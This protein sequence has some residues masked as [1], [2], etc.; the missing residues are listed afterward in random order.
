MS[1][2]PILHREVRVPPSPTSPALILNIDTVGSSQQR[3]LARAGSKRS[4]DEISSG[5]DEETYARKHLATEG[6]VFFRSSQR[7]PRS[8]LWRTLDDRRVLEIQAV[9]IVNDSYSGEGNGWL[10]YRVHFQDAIL[11]GGVVLADPEETDA[12]ECFVFTE[13]K[14]LFTIT[15]KRDLLTRATLPA[16]F[17]SATCVKRYS[18]SFLGLR[19]PYR[20]HAASS[21]ELL[22]SLTDGSLVRL[23]RRAG[24]NGAQWRETIFSEGGWSGSFSLKKMIPFSSQRTVRYGDSELDASAIVD[25]ARTPDSLHIWTLTLDHWLKMW[26]IKTGKVVSKLDL[27][28]EARDEAR[29][30]PFVMSAE[31]GKLMQ[32][33]RIRKSPDSN[34]VMQVDEEQDWASAYY[35]VVQSPKDHQFKFYKVTPNYSSIEGHT[36]N[37]EDQHSRNKLIPPVDELM[38]TNVW[39]LEDFHVR[40]GFE[41]VDTMLWIR[42][43]S[44]TLCRTFALTFDLLMSEDGEAPNTS[45]TWRNAWSA[46]D[47]GPL[48]SEELKLS[49]GYPGELEVRSE[50]ASTPSEKWLAFLFYPDRFSL[51][52]LDAALYIYRK[53]RGL[54]STSSRGVKAA[55]QPLEERLATAITSKIMLKRSANDQPDYVRYQQDIQ[56]QWQTYYSLLSHLHNRRHEPIG[57]AFDNAS[58]LAWS[59][60]ADYVAPIRECSG[61]ELRILNTHLLD[62]NATF[63]VDRKLHGLIYPERLSKS[64]ANSYES[65]QL[66]RLLAAARDLRRSLTGPVQEKIRETAATAALE[67][68]DPSETGVSEPGRASSIFDICN[69]DSEVT[70]EDFEALSLGVESLGGLGSLQDFSILGILEWI[71]TEGNFAGHDSGAQLTPFGPT[72]LTA[73]VEETLRRSESIL[74]ELITLVVFMAGGLEAEELDPEFNADQ[75]YDACVDRLRRVDLLLWLVGHKRERTIRVG[76][77]EVTSEVTLFEDVFVGDWRALQSH[78]RESQTM[79]ELLTVWIKAWISGIKCHGPA[80]EGTT[81]HIL[82]FLVN[83]KESDLALDFLPFMTAETTSWSSY[84]KARMCVDLGDYAQAS[85]YFKSAAEGCAA[86]KNIDSTDTAELLSPDEQ[87]YFGSGLAAYHQHVAALFE[88]LRVYSYVADFARLALR[89]TERIPDF[90]AAMARLDRKKQVHDSPARD[91]ISVAQE[92]QRLLKIKEAR[93]DILNRL[94]NAL[95]QTGRWSEAYEA[96]KEIE[97]QPMKRADLRRLLESCVKSRAVPE[98]LALPFEGELGIEADKALLGMAKKDLASGTSKVAI[99]TYQVL[100]AFRTQ[101]QDFRGAA[102]ILYEHLERLRHTPYHHPAHDPEDEMLVNVYVLL[103]NTLACCG[104]EDAWLL[105]EPIQGVHREG[106]KRKLVTLADL[107]REYTAELDKRSDM[108]HGR[109]A[110]VGGEEDAAMDVL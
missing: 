51:A 64:D 32:L 107:R 12:L 70:D 66:S 36:V 97:D 86:D 56:E 88:R 30:T 89:Q 58:G 35:L 34:E 93:D 81:T 7:A 96:L 5:L 108:L 100:Y 46:V 19:Q 44:G 72:V 74:L 99:P 53:G 49:P 21:L 84:V 79:S 38:N 48:R 40:P 52:S 59:I 29:K 39:H 27:L 76:N 31:Q 77:A 6:S 47:E 45:A 54:P 75:M 71:D 18:S 26:S 11:P 61:L 94:F 82:A 3:A 65:V 102:E 1:P 28:N 2:P 41:W 50:D 55:E 98:L 22:V 91:R 85:H 103:I 42:A 87:T 63:D 105:A 57:L 20:F 10:T 4:F 67:I 15:L 43:R 90:A 110:L 23:E 13:S 17:D 25:M 62:N 73:G 24:E 33:L 106:S 69:L 60:C 68:A 8:F 80:W 16:E 37:V 9:D 95:V 104:E 109:F 101:R 92:E 78:R 83:R 14:E